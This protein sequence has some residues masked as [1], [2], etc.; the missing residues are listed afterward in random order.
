MHRKSKS[1]LK[2]L[3][4]L[5]SIKIKETAPKIKDSKRV[6]QIYNK[7]IIEKAVLEKEVQITDDTPFSVL[8]R[9]FKKFSK[10]K[11]RLIA[12]YFSVPLS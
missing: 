3:I 5:C 7:Y 1:E 8:K 10:P 9:F 4:K 11:G 2:E 6:E 12:D